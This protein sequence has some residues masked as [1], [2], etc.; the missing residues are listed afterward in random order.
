MEF[1]FFCKF[2]IIPNLSHQVTSMPIWETSN[3][4]I[5]I[6]L[7]WW[8]TW[9]WLMQWYFRYSMSFLLFKIFALILGFWFQTSFYFLL[10]INGMKQWNYIFRSGYMFYDS[11]LAFG[12]P[13]NDIHKEESAVETWT[14]NE[15]A[16]ATNKSKHW[17]IRKMYV[18]MPF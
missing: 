13:F 4:P 11:L 8:C 9:L 6:V 3:I 5:A 2:I 12:S 15:K 10:H 17:Y 1:N 16:M 18:Y 7:R 14:M